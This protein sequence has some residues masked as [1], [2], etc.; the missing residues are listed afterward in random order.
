MPA[1]TTITAPYTGTCEYLLEIT[2]SGSRRWIATP[3]TS[4]G[5]RSQPVRDVP[6]CHDTEEAAAQ[7][8]ADMLG[9]SVETAGDEE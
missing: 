1:T 6:G 7:A 5:F 2:A 8:L 4:D 3:L 9:G